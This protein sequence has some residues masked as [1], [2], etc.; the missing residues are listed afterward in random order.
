MPANPELHHEVT[1][2]DDE[3]LLP[4]EG[5]KAAPLGLQPLAGALQARWPAGGKR[6]IHHGGGAPP[7]ACSSTTATQRPRSIQWPTPRASRSPLSTGSSG[8]STPC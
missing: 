5:P 8:P 4:G 7:R 6:V 2:G 3:Q 1:L